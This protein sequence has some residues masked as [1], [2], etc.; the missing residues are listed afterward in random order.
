L[1]V[2]P[3][4]GACG[5]TVT[6]VDLARLDDNTF[7]QVLAAWHTHGVLAFPHQH[8][9]EEAHVAFSRR[10]GQLENTN[11]R[12][13]HSAEHRP[14]TLQLANIN[15]RGE[16]VSDPEARLNRHLRGNQFW[17]TDSSFKRIS[18]KASLLAAI[19]VPDAGGETEYA[20][21][22]AAYDALDPVHHQQLDRLVAVHS[23]VWSQSLAMGED[24]ALPPEE[25]RNL[26]PVRHPLVRV[27]EPTGRRSLF[28]GRHARLVEGLD[29][30]ASRH[31]LDG[32]LE[33][34]CQP[35]RVYRHRWSAGDLV[36][37]DNRCMLH[38]GL[39][40]DTRQARVMRRTTVAGEASPGDVNEWLL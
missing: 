5:A 33:V 26:P 38:R 24:H 12:D 18:A 11:T 34:A 29:E 37:W 20:D 2:T 39:P 13:P 40:W 9:S 14:T 30:A 36:L 32:L 17:H 6:G 4:R 7:T 23:I 21:M 15:R 8:L 31:L 22:R 10:I 3:H 16:L 27:H 28:I 1:T 35:P 25:E 19:Q